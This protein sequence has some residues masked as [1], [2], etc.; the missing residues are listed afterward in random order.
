M[1]AKRK[2]DQ[3]R[4]R[5]TKEED[6]WLKS[7][8]PILGH[9]EGYKRFCEQF[10][11]R[12]PW[13]A[14]KTRTSEL[15]IKVTDERW[16]EACANNGARENVPI[17]TIQKRG[18]GGNWIKVASGTEGW[19]PLSQYLK[20]PRDGYVVIHLDGDKSNDSAENLREVSRSVLARMSKQHF[21]SEEP[22]I[23]ETGIKCCELQQAMYERREDDG[24]D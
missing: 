14:Y 18:R 20:K 9:A 11:N 16:R 22:I 8:H 12:H 15:R 24:S 13:S 2:T 19:I 5:W 3:R 21:W 7:H 6:E 4:N 10:G 17:G 1:S 23:T